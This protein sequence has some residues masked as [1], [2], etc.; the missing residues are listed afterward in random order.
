MRSS[1]SVKHLAQTGPMR[2]LEVSESFATGTM[3]VIR[4]IAAG[5]T[6][7]GHRVAIAY[8][9]RPETPADLRG[10]I[11]DEVELIELP[12][13]GRTMRTQL[14]TIPELRRTCRVWRPDVIHLHSSFAGFI[15]ALSVTRLAPSIYTP[16]G[17]SFLGA[18]PG[19]T[20]IAYRL[21]ERL[22]AR[23]VA[24]VGAVSESEARRAREVGARSVVVVP[25]GIA[26]LDPDRL[27][28]GRVPPPRGRPLVVSMGR[29]VPQRRPDE[30]ARILHAV[31]DL[32]DTLWIGGPGVDPA[33]EDDVRSAGI[34]V[35]GWTDRDRALER[36]AE[37]TV[38]LNWSAWDSHPLTVLEAMAFDVLVIASDIEA[39]RDLVGA[40]QVGASEED[41]IA[42]LRAALTDP[43]RR[44]KMLA[45]Q[46]RRRT[47]FGRERMV[48]DW[49][50]LYARLASGDESR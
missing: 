13:T 50:G 32:A 49:L 33:L 25:N 10:Q 36:L 5:A 7:Q 17:Y 42:M 48:R 19:A 12:W 4:E 41:G 30:T 29:I 18:R 35:T 14:R 3:E 21:A 31:S 15:G 46:R 22:V 20:R 44:E 2:I 43:R 16:H 6:A 47:A 34:E 24:V 28:L 9:K 26:D 27:S 40:D 45:E 38:F 8:G 23:R 11:P 1:P 39:N 37:A